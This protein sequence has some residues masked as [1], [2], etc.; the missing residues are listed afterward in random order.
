M[1]ALFLYHFMFSKLNYVFHVNIGQAS[2]FFFSNVEHS[3][4]LQTMSNIIFF[5]NGWVNEGINKY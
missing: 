2:T 3:A 5:R 1:F 4:R